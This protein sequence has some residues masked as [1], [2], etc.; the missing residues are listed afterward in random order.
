VKK[1]T[2]TAFILFLTVVLAA[3]ALLAAS[4]LPA[5]AKLVL[6]NGLTVYFLKS[7]D[8]PVVS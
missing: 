3:P 2:L 1:L 8:L 6:K 4:R 5:P 7:S